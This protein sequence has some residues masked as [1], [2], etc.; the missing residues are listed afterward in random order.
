MICK[1]CGAQVPEKA[2]ECPNCHT[3]VK[4]NMVLTAL[5]KVAHEIQKGTIQKNIKE[6]KIN[7]PVAITS[8]I[9]VIAQFLPVYK[10]EMYGYSDSFTAFEDFGRTGAIVFVTALRI[11]FAMI[12]DQ[13]LGYVLIFGG[14]YFLNAIYNTWRTHYV[15]SSVA[16]V[17]EMGIGIYLALLS[18]AGILGACLFSL[19]K[20]G[21]NWKEFKE[22]EKN[23]GE[24]KGSNS[25]E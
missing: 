21:I 22:F 10:M 23:R 16:G 4:K 7:I 3:P 9:A 20:Y 8:L 11:L 13:Y 24:N 18:G 2:T 14:L 17:G 5:S 19:K 1:R 25:E 12:G 6:G 15:I